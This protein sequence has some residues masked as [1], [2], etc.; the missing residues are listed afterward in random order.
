MYRKSRATLTRARVTW[1]S[2]KLVAPTEKAI[3]LTPVHANLG[4]EAAYRKKLQA[5][6]AEMSNSVI[7]WTRSTWK[8]NPPLASIAQDRMGYRQ[9][10]IDLRRTMDRLA[11]HWQKRFDELGPELAKV[12]VDGATATT[13]A[14]MMASLKNA[15][16]SVKFQMTQAAKEGY[17]AVL[18]ENVGLIKSIPS[19]YLTDVQQK[20]WGAVKSGHDLETLTKG[21]QSD[22]G[23]SFRRASL[24]ARDQSNK[25]KAV[26]ENVR[27]KE[28][29]ITQAIWQHSGGGKEPRPDHV[30]AGQDKLVYD[31]DKGAYIG[32]KWILP[33][34]EINCRCTSRAI[35][36]G[37]ED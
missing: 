29:G 4:I 18:Q 6:I 3:K 33:G 7:Y 23:V 22:Y 17:Q 31:L 16:F 2:R 5:L 35:I 34:T 14:A 13:D 27:R 28:L 36:P 24:I 11:R 37:F 25:A 21:L 9:P 19:E 10:L 8:K 26:I 1:M 32:G 15:G 12:F 20:V 30:K